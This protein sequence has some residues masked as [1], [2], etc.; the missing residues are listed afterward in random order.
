M[1][2]GLVARKLLLY[3]TVI[4]KHRRRKARM[5]NLAL[6]GQGRTHCGV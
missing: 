1:T 3:N 6:I 2:V 5:D 4:G